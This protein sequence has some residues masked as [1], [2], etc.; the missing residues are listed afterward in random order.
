MLGH[1]LVSGHRIVFVDPSV[2]VH[3]SAQQRQQV[4]ADEHSTCPAYSTGYRATCTEVL[5]GFTV[6]E[7]IGPPVVVISVPCVICI[8]ILSIIVRV[9]RWWRRRWRVIV[10]LV[11]L[12]FFICVIVGTLVV[13]MSVVALISRDTIARR[14]NGTTD[15]TIVMRDMPGPEVLNLMSSELTQ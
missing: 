14:G 8:V 1:F 12:A 10:I 4:Q 15:V 13:G 5:S 9:S 3:L 6:A 2:V 7:G 11:L